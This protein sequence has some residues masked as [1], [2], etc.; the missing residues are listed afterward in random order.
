MLTVA[1]M[2]VIIGDHASAGTDAITVCRD[3]VPAKAELA[4]PAYDA[5]VRR[6]PSARRT[7]W[8]TRLTSC[9]TAETPIGAHR[10]SASHRLH[11]V[12]FGTIIGILGKALFARDAD[13]APVSA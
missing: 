12:A 8:R 7:G 13:P 6:R 11:G 1:L 2:L 9:T 10:P 5:I 3:T 4:I